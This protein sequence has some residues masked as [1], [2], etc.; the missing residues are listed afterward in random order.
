MFSVFG[1]GGDFYEV[2]IDVEGESK[3]VSVVVGGVRCIE[4]LN[5]FGM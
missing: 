1:L 2:K 3:L 5:E 4:K